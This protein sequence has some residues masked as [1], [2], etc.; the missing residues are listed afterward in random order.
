M[1]QTDM[2]LLG[3]YA[4]NKSEAAFASLVS[5]HVN[6]VY[7]VALRLVCDGHLAEEVTQTVII[8]LAR[9]AARLP[10]DTIVAGW[11]YRTT[12]FAAMKAMTLVRRRHDREQ[13]AYMRSQLNQTDRDPWA[14][15]EPLLEAA[16][17]EL[18][19][20]DQNALVLRFFEGRGFKEISSALNTTEAAAKMRV[21]RAL[22]KLRKLLSRRGLTVSAAILAGALSV[23]A[24]QG[25][26]VG[27]AGSVTVAAVNGTGLPVSTL[28]LID[29]TWKIMA[30]TKLKT[31][32][33]VG[34]IAIFALG[35]ASVTV[36]YARNRSQNTVFRFAGYATP[37]N[38]MQTM[39]YVAA[40]GDLTRLPSVLTLDEVESFNGKM[41]GR[42]P[43]EIRQALTSWAHAMRDYQITQKDVVSA[44][45]A[46]LHIHATPSAEGLHS[47]KVVIRMKKIS[48]EWKC[49][50]DLN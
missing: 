30:W 46:H 22:E 14:D 49:A 47:G 45:E 18:G 48:G 3:E 42:S 40:Q 19:Q 15:I 24:V 34:A 9:K 44:D 50:G 17:G 43:A 2:E 12:R 11:L 1:M 13:E 31:T 4:H 7:S 25:A 21:N 27:L 26:P 36:Q 39:L 5:R 23:G 8:I 16:M 10:R 38:S 20:E 35:T 28:T 29:K 6:L 33:V 32:L 37:E 41:A